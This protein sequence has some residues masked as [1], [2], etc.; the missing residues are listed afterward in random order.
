MKQIPILLVILMA[1]CNGSQNGTDGG[2]DGD[3]GTPV[4]G[5]CPF[6]YSVPQEHILED[7][8]GGEFAAK[9]AHVRC[10]ISH[11]NVEA[12]I[13]IKYE[14]VGVQY[15]YPIYEPRQGYVC[16]NGQVEQLPDGTFNFAWKH[17]SWKEVEAAFD[18][19]R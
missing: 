9:D 10:R 17:H 12:Q 2:S 8:M 5:E 15:Y 14:P 16:K 6:P 1:A 3:G 11:D 18:G 13:F 7:E 19:R 4:F